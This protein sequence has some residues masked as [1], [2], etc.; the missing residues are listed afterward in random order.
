MPMH[1]WTRVSDGAY[2]T[3]H[4]LWAGDICRALNKGILPSDYYA[5]IESR[6]VGDVPDLLTLRDVEPGSELGPSAGTATAVARRFR[7][8]GEVDLFPPRKSV[9]RVRNNYD[10]RVVALVE[11]VS[12]GN[13]SSQNPFRDFI[14]KIVTTLGEGVNVLVVD[15]FPPTKRDPSGVHA[16][17]WAE[18]GGPPPPPLPADEQL[19]TIAYQSGEPVQAFGEPFAVGAVIPH[20][21]IF[22]NGDLDVTVPLEET[23]MS[24]YTAVPWKTRRILE[25]V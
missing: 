18:I 25:A 8:K 12:P 21:P 16:A 6:V 17:V 20:M 14:R 24:A 11:L 22:L 15:P 2:H 10:D 5:D 4:Q 13:K 1:D 3:L 19:L 7:I 9:V 23:Y